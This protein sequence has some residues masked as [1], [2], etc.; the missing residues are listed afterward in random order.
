VSFILRFSRCLFPFKRPSPPPS[1]QYGSTLG[2]RR[3]IKRTPHSASTC[4]ALFLMAASFPPRLGPSS[5]GCRCVNLSLTGT[6]DSPIIYAINCL[7]LLVLCFLYS[8]ISR[9][10]FRQSQPRPFG[11]RDT[12]LV[13]TDKNRTF[14]IHPHKS[15][16]PGSPLDTLQQPAAAQG[17]VSRLRRHKSLRIAETLTRHSSLYRSQ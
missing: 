12:R 10:L 16:E 17:I 14:N 1:L 9:P 15:A 6:L 13:V 4:L 2:H 7:I 8:L 3:A 11:P 5:L